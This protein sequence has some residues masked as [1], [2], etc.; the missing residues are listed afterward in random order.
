MGKL[1]VGKVILNL[2]KVILSLGKGY[3]ILGRLAVQS[4]ESYPKP[5]LN[6]EKGYPKS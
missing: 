5:I 3:P 4:A 1:N 6:P 2:E